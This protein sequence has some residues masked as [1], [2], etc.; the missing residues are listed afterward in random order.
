MI[1]GLLRVFS[2]IS[3]RDKDCGVGIVVCDG[4]QPIIR[5]P[6]KHK[7][8]YGAYAAECLGYIYS[9]AIALA[10][11]YPSVVLHGDADAVIERLEGGNKLEMYIANFKPMMD[12]WPFEGD[13]FQVKLDKDYI[14]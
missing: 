2:D 3:L 8:E 5:I 1:D 6:I 14:T 13:R 12:M 4:D 11:P 9:T 10:L 7:V